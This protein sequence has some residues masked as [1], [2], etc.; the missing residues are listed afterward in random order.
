MDIRILYKR[1]RLE[2]QNAVTTFSQAEHLDSEEAQF[3]GYIPKE[4]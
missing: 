2:K 1:L 3:W 4:S